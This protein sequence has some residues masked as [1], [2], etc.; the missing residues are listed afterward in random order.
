[1]QALC[2]EA[3]WKKASY[4]VHVDLN[5]CFICSK[6]KVT[7]FTKVLNLNSRV[8]FTLLCLFFIFILLCFVFFFCP[9]FTF[10]LLSFYDL[11]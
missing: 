3:D 8:K 1:M 9:S 10:L 7:Y 11:P 2:P 5:I 4:S 6:N